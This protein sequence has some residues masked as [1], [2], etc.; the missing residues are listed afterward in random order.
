MCGINRAKLG[1]S[2]AIRAGST[3]S[4]DEV[5]WEDWAPTVNLGYQKSKPKSEAS[6]QRDQRMKLKEDKQKRHDCAETLLDLQ[7]PDK[8]S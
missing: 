4:L 5:E 7:I 8:Q 6:L 1:P 3:S 2:G